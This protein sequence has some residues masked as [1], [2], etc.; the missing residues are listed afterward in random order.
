MLAWTLALALCFGGTLTYALAD[1]SSD[2]QGQINSAASGTAIEIT[3]N[4]TFS[5]AVTIPE[6]KDITIKSG[7]SGP[8]TL[9]QANL[10]TRHFVVE[11]TLTLEDIILN[12]STDGSIETAQGGGIKVETAGNLVMKDG[13]VIQY[14]L[15]AAEN[16]GGAVVV[17]GGAFAM[18][19]GEIRENSA[20]FFGLGGG[21][22]LL[23]EA[24]LTVGDAQNSNAAPVITE[25]Y[26]YNGAGIYCGPEGSV[27]VFSSAQISDNAA[28][29][30]GGG[31]YGEGSCP[32]EIYGLAEIFENSAAH[33]GG[34]VCNNLI[35][36][37][38]NA[39]IR[40]NTAG[41][42]GGGLCATMTD[43]M[44]IT[45]IIAVYGNAKVTGNEAAAHGGG[46]YAKNY[47][48]MNPSSAIVYGAGAIAATAGGD[49]AA[50]RADNVLGAPPAPLSVTIYG[51]AEIRENVAGADG[52]G[53][54]VEKLENV[55]VGANVVFANNSASEG[56]E[57]DINNP[58]NVQQQWDAAI[59][60]TNI[61]TASFTT[62]YTNAY[63]NFDINCSGTHYN[64]YVFYDA[65][66]GE[67]SYLDARLMMF[68]QYIVLELSDTGITRSGYEFTGWMSKLDGVEK[69]YAPG[70]NFIIRGNEILYAQ[71]SYNGGGGVEEPEPE[72]YTVTYDANGGTGG[73]E[74]TGIA[75]GTIYRILANTS[76]GISRPGY[77][78]T[79]WNTQK[80]GKGT[81]YSIFERVTIESDLTLY[82]QWKENISGGGGVVNPTIEIEDDIPPLATFT[83]D[84][85]AYVIG[86][87]D[88]NVRPEANILRS[89]VTTVFF[90]LLNETVRYD[91]WGTVNGYKD[92]PTEKWCNNSIS[93]M[94]NLG[95]ITGYPNGNFGPEDYVTRGEL[96]TIAAR[97]ARL[98][99]SETVA[100]RSFSDISGHWAEKYILFAAN[101]GWLSGYT[102]GSFRPD[103]YITRSEFIAIVNRMLERS[104]ENAGDLL[105]NMITW[106]DNKDTNK[107][108]YLDMQE[109]TNSHYYEF[110]DNLVPGRSYPYETWTEFR[111]APDW[112]VLEKPDSEPYDLVISQ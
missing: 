73:Y 28:G 91:Y 43:A 17:K 20:T 90:R 44:S 58:L 61:L 14:C 86:Y 74:D 95:V 4:M 88:G 41:D 56:Y 37:Y 48:S 65:N 7:G 46:I 34:G 105:S 96:A 21:I 42:Y 63:S 87:T 62:P 6:G 98:N 22:A 104:P 18:K 64:Y 101:V 67:G 30:S 85:F 107:W 92:V 54:Y 80:D 79:G 103:E 8:Y 38:D 89:E 94:T 102:D 27:K 45:T 97:F 84:H 50:A 35:N 19:G 106:P 82:A 112:S 3:G 36:V 5:T 83:T 57:W 53:I 11:G 77:T 55:T 1:G 33:F 93:V 81:G 69:E 29:R 23:G 70:E 111:G 47:S 10:G 76:V 78:F 32:I 9:T 40:D 99:G 12:G 13:A 60:K 59:H 16:L 68:S 109:A 31:I 15:A 110:K 2:L 51:N 24:A 26:A 25:N 108:Y 39:K 100:S 71:W 75:E 66:G 72:T 49:G 52:G